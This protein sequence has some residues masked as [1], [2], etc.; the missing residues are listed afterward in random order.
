MRIVIV[1][2][3]KIR[4]PFFR[5]A[6]EHYLARIQ[7]HVRAD[8]VEIDPRRRPALVAEAVRAAV[9][10]RAVVAALDP[11]GEALSSRG[12][13]DRVAS[14][15][16]SGRPAVAFL[17]GGPD[18]LPAGTAEGADTRLSMGQLTLPHRLA[19]VVLLE[20]IYRALTILRGEP[21]DK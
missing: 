10:A 7:R 21:Y 19:R 12:F 13:A 2:I 20:Q 14:W 11:A 8:V 9:P 18:G 4:E 5:E 1:A 16:R 17:V 3:G 15:Q 6:A